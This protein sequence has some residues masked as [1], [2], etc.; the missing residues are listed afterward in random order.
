VNSAAA[1]L[2]VRSV[3]NAQTEA[4]R[5]RSRNGERPSSGPRESGCREIGPPG[6]RKVVRSDENI[7]RIGPNPIAER[8]KTEYRGHARAG[9]AKSSPSGVEK[10]RE[11]RGKH[12]PNRAEHV[13]Q[14]G[15]KAN[16]RTTRKRRSGT[17]RTRT[18][19]IRGK[20]NW[21]YGLR[22]TSPDRVQIAVSR[23]FDSPTTESVFADRRCVASIA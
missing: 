18:S 7:N 15:A 6:S 3:D 10:G 17:R 16:Y 11:A 4:L 21:P 9:P 22:K 13:R 2:A 23:F 20:S 5:N 14:G 8:R 19:G 1:E 12:Q